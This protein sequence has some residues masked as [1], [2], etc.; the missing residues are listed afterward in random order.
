MLSY[1]ICLSSTDFEIST[2]PLNEFLIDGDRIIKWGQTESYSVLTDSGIN[3][4]SIIW[5]FMNTKINAQT[6]Q[7]SLNIST[8]LC[9][10]IFYNND[11]EGFVCIDVRVLGANVYIPN[12]FSKNPDSPNRIFTVFTNDEGSFIRSFQI[13][14]RWGNLVFDKANQDI[15]SPEIQ[16][17]G[18]FQGEQLSQGVYVYV[19]EILFTNGEE[20][21]IVGDVTL[22]D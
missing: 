10:N 17:D 9:A 19:I 22:I 12:V 20:R 5:T 18:S 11:C 13:Y 16:W 21:R 14:D 7:I 2:P 6:A 3:I 4:D 15:N 1:D 8:R